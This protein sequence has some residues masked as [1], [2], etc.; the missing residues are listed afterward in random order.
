MN[1]GT[2]RNTKL[3]YGFGRRVAENDVAADDVAGHVPACTE[4]DTVEVSS[5]F[6]ILDQVV[7]AYAEEP[8]PEIVAIRSGRA[9]LG[10]S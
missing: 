9:G 7:L 6:I 1:I 5:D 8:Q 3:S 4:I 2:D 10:S